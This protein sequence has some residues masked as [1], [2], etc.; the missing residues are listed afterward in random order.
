MTEIDKKKLL[1][2]VVDIGIKTYFT[3]PNY[4]KILDELSKD[5]ANG[6][7]FTTLKKVTKT[8]SS[9]LNVYLKELIG[10]GMVD[11][12]FKKTKD[13]KEYSFY[14]ITEIGTIINELAGNVLSYLE[15]RVKSQILEESAFFNEGMSLGPKRHFNRPES[16]KETGVIARFTHVSDVVSYRKPGNVFIK[17]TDFSAQGMYR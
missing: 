7:S 2:N 11:N 15:E 17:P 10:S 13:T 5:T 16:W 12:Y 1:D 6:A 8:N 3:S 4:R 9:A 14:K